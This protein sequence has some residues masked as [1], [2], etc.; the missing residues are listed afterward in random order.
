[1]KD[2]PWPT[3]VM[4]SGPDKGETR[5]ESICYDIADAFVVTVFG[6][7]ILK[8]CQWDDTNT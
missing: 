6:A 4:K 1:M 2:F 8:K 3:K 5:L 7:D